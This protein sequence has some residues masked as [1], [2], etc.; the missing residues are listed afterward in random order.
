MFDS[1]LSPWNRTT[2]DNG[3]VVHFH[4]SKDGK[5]YVWSTVVAGEG[6][7]P[8]TDI[9]HAA[10][11][12]AGIEVKAKSTVQ[13]GFYSASGGQA[14]SFLVDLPRL[15]SDTAIALVV[16]SL[17]YNGLGSFIQG[18]TPAHHEWIDA[19]QKLQKAREAMVGTE[20]VQYM[21]AKQAFVEAETAAEVAMEKAAL[22]T[23]TK[24]A[25]TN[26]LKRWPRFGAGVGA[27][28]VTVI[29]TYLFDKY[30]LP[31]IVQDFFIKI[32]IVNLDK[33]SWKIDEWYHDNG[34]IAGGKDF[35]LVTLGP[36]SGMFVTETLL[37]HY[38]DLILGEKVPFSDKFADLVGADTVTYTI[39][40][41]TSLAY[42]IHGQ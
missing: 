33:Q 20:G 22:E 39:Q 24:G 37:R 2:L 23:S 14:S 40:N 17:V 6:D 21:T 13:V 31:H 36:P 8:T 1:Q 30:V 28:A 10:N 34:I 5:S 41:C 16:G 9:E 29:A 42:N 12:P 18:L 27:L 38:T 19:A 3:K 35:E 25:F 15:A 26:F 7:E 11:L 4:Q 32:N